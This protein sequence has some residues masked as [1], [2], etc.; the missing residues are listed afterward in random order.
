MLYRPNEITNLDTALKVLTPEYSEYNGV[1]SKTYEKKPYTNAPQFFG[2]FKQKGGTER[3]I[4]GVYSI[5]DTAEIV[6]WYR[7][8]ITA[9]CRIVRLPGGEVYDVMGEPENVDNRGQF[10]KFKVQRVKGEV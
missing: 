9:D 3:D 1:R 4:N 5:L 6:T 7:A 10:L 8:D 2:S